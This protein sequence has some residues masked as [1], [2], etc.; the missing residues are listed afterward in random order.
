MN[1][2]TRELNRVF[3][4]AASKHQAHDQARKV[5][6]DISADPSFLTSVLEQH[7]LTPDAL[8]RSNYPV[9]ALDV[10]SN[11]DYTLVVNCWI[12]LPGRETDLCT[13][14]IH[15]HGAMLLTTA[16]IFGPGYEHW[17][18]TCPTQVDP[19][20]ELF[21][22]EVLAQQPHP[23]HHVSFVD[24]YIAHL[25]FYPPGLSITAALWSNQS[26]TSWKD[27][28]KRIPILKRNENTLR[29]LAV[30]AGLAKQL[31]LKVDDYKDFYPVHD[32]FQGMRERVEF[33]LGPNID[34]LQSLFHVLQ[35][36][37]NDQIIPLVRQKLDSP[38]SL[39]NPQKVAQLLEELRRG[40]TIDGRLSDCHLGVP[41]TT[42]TS[43]DIERALR[44]QRA[45]AAAVGGSHGR[46][47]D[48]SSVPEARLVSDSE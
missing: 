20:R 8:N 7:L 14:A 38:A 22:M 40:R 24:A 4:N 23:L 3:R 6:E 18:F 37:G 32:G 25:P 41:H 34:Y 33:Q 47:F 19:V 13:K 21:T 31:D 5:L 26:A 45:P 48:G 28:I 11:P 30:R 15:H 29:K 12:P 10:E 1:G 46:Q 42:F 2:Y 35:Q 27:R 39:K 16:T 36:T 9:L 44:A 43:Q 17:M